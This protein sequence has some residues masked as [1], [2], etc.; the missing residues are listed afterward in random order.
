M[1]NFNHIATLKCVIREKKMCTY[2]TIVSTWTK[3][4]KCVPQIILCS[5]ISFAKKKLN[6][7]NEKT[8]RWAIIFNLFNF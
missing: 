1:D 4:S 3:L 7:T 6:E 5:R 2:T 8:G